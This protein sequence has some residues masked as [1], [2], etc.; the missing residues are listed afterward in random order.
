MHVY[1][2]GGRGGGGGGGGGNT[3]VCKLTDEPGMIG[4]SCW[5][6]LQAWLGFAYK[7]HDVQIIEGPQNFEV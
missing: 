6:N 4:C 3:G 1:P 2:L 7:L 5:Y